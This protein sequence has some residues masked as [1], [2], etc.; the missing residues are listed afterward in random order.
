[1]TAQMTCGEALIQLLERYGVDT[2]FGIPGEHTLELYRGIRNGNVR[3]VLARNEQGAGF[4]ADGYG[5]STGRPGVCTITGPG[6]TNAATPMGQAYADSIPLLVISSANAS[7]TL[8]KGWGCL[9]EISD[10][11]AVTAPLTAFSA[12][13]R[14]P[15]DLPE[16]IAQA[17]T[18]FRSAR[19]RPIPRLRWTALGRR[20]GFS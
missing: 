20:S 8:G 18:V 11:R 3:H 16:L 10:Q 12:M 19:P 7:E 9:H 15:E 2:V 14:T 17:F 13:I 4:M 5:R 6:V 1:M